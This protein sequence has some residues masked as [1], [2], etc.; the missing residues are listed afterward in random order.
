MKLSPRRKE[1]IVTHATTFPRLFSPFPVRGFVL[2][3]RIVSTSH[4]AHFGVNGLPTDRYIR[5]HVEKAKG[6]AAMVQAFGTTSVHPT[7]PGGSGNINNWDDSI[8]P[9][10]RTLAEQVHAHGAIIT[11]QLVHRGRRATSAVT[12]M[13]LLAPTDQ[14]NERTGETPRAMSHGD[15]KMVIDAYAAAAERTCRAGFDGVEIAMFGDMLPDEFLSPTVNTRT[16]EYGGTFEHRLRFPT[17]LLVAVREAIGRERLLIVRLSGDDFLPDELTLSERISVARLFEALDIVD[18]FSITGGTV[19]TLQGRP[20]H[21]PSSY[22]P[23]GVYLPLA[24]AFKAQLRAPILYAGR[25]VHPEEAEAALAEGAADLIGMTRAIIADPEMPR[26]A[27]EGRIEDIRPCVGANE[28]CIGRLYQG[29]PI[30]CVHNPLIG[31]EAELADL[32]LAPMRRRVVVIGGGPAG[33]EAARVAAL[34]GHEVILVERRAHLGGQVLTAAQAPGRG[35]FAGIVHWLEWQLRKLGVDIRLGVEAG[36]HDVLALGGEVT[37]LATGA[38]PRMP[39]A[40]IAPGTRLL[41]VTDV[42]DGHVTPSRHVHMIVEDPHMAGPTTAD[43]LA[44]RG[45]VVT[46][47]TPSYTVGEALDDTLKPIILERLLTQGVRLVPLHRAIEIHPDRIV[48]VHTLTG[49]RATFEAESVVVA[50]GGRANDSL[51]DT[52]RGRIAALFVVGD[53]MAPRRVHDAVLEGTRV[54]RQV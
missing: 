54:G 33:L 4:D 23:H 8:I 51:S 21:V 6:G 13:P 38:L 24:R 35:E 41:T 27:A 14:P 22:F 39:N 9:P 45:H 49:E 11:C 15:I 44:A 29:L 2:K 32:H 52:L 53:A 31:R 46:I 36:P 34:R 7:S 10:F 48:A 12:R 30:E 50:S 26:K 40:K 25:I 19:K 20:R 1:Q 28:G 16:D 18:L 42:L 43:F 37:I 47:L 5:Y 17:E 3:N